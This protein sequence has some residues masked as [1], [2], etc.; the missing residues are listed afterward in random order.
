VVVGLRLITQARQLVVV[1]DQVVVAQFM[2]QEAHQAG[3]QELQVKE[4][5]VLLLH[6]QDLV[7]VQE[8]EAVQDKQDKQQAELKVVLVVMD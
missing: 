7:M 6:L 5:M 3:V 8:V 1:A 2:F 4:Q